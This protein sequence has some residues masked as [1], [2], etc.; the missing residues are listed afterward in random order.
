MSQRTRNI[1]FRALCHTLTLHNPMV[2]AGQ[3]ALADILLDGRL[4][5]GLGRGHAWLHG[6][7][8]H[9][10]RR[11]RRALSRRPSRSCSRRGRRTAS[12]S[13]ASTTR[14]KDLRSCPK[15][16]Q[17]PHPPIWQVGTSAKWVERAVRNGWGV[18]L[19]G[20]APNIAFEEADQQVPRGL[21]G[22]RRARR[23]S[24]TSRP[25]YLDEDN[26]RAIEEGAR[27]AHELHP[28]QRRRRPTRST[29]SP[30]GKQ[31][32]IDARY[33]F[34]AADDFPNTRNLSYEQLL[35][36]D[37]VYAGSP[38]KVAE[39]LID[40]L[41]PVPLR[42]VPADRELRRQHALAGDAQPG[43][44]RARHHAAHARGGPLGRAA[45]S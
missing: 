7:G 27:V 29:A 10:A 30:E 26:D 13:T 36:L 43:A 3:I 22:A 34:Y 44:V 38:D 12:R 6:A 9:R 33:E 11:E 40:L 20:P 17:K 1:R 24:P 15:P 19:G 28:L 41:G 37:I 42:R 2:L 39:Q 4:E 18:A 23:T 21:R 14:R 31:K 16:I 5:V 8:E 32:L 35:D 45:V 25:V